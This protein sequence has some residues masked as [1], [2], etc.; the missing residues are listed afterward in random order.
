MNTISLVG[1]VVADHDGVKSVGQTQVRNFHVAS[2]TG[3][4]DRKSTLWPGCAIWGAR[5][6]KLA[7]YQS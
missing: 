6:E 2:D 1:R 3:F 7:P 4:G 5:A